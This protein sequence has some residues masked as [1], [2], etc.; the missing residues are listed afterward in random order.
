L[1]FS[2][3]YSQVVLPELRAVRRAAAA[4]LSGFEMPWQDASDEN[5]TLIALAGLVAIALLALLV[6]AAAHRS[7]RRPRRRGSARETTPLT[8]RDPL[9]PEVP[10]TA[11]EGEIAPELVY[12]TPR[13]PRWV[14]LG[15]I[16]VALGLTW[17]VAQRLRPA[18]DRASDEPQRTTPSVASADSA[19]PEASSSTGVPFAFRARAWTDEGA[20]CRS[21]L[22]VTEGSSAPY[23]L[24]LDVHD[25][26]GR[27][28][29]RATA[30]VAMLRPGETVEFRLRD[31]ACDR[32]AAW[33]VR[34]EESR[35]R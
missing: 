3:R 30:R 6:A 24:T 25:H 18:S 4:R 26:G 33:E 12:D 16:V 23:E 14:Q 19:R 1:T 13:L 31:V 29:G 21:A 35:R 8:Y 9:S 7:R 5:R 11:R 10:G 28:L 20:G 32:I 34:G 22:E 17:T 2:L 27:L 15:S